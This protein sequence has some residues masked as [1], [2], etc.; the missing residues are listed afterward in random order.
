MQLGLRSRVAG[1]VA[2]KA[3]GPPFRLRRRGGKEDLGG[4]EA[5][6]SRQGQKRAWNE[7]GGEQKVYIGANC[8]GKA[9]MGH[10]QV[11]SSLIINSDLCANPRPDALHCHTPV[12][13]KL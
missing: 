1:A 8:C 3:Q 9:M 6:T 12:T 7:A 5:K 10:L 13:S 11:R 4:A 2:R